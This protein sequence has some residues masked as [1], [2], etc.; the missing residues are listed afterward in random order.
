M[1]DLGGVLSLLDEKETNLQI[2][3]LKKL[4][5]LVD[6]F[7]HEIAD[8]ISKMCFFRKVLGGKLMKN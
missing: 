4:N 2:H 6:Q 1:R 7:W 5:E 8:E 3:A